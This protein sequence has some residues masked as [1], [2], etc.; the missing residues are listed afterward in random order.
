MSGC[1]LYLQPASKKEAM[2]ILLPVDDSP[3]SQEA[4]RSLLAEF[5]TRGTEVRVL[6]VIESVAAY[7]TADMVPEIVVDTAKIEA[8]RLKQSK[9]LVAETA[10]K[11][12]DAGFAADEAVETGDPKSVILDVAENWPADLIV[13]GS[14]GL[15]GL[16]RFLLGSVSDA[17]SRHATCSVQ[18]VRV[19]PAA[20]H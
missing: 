10:K 13:L 18:V 9:T 6:H 5:Q 17:V 7:L 8:E 11:L 12:R 20:G 16:N 4:V 14:H 2:R 19:R 15:K 1:G 3:Y